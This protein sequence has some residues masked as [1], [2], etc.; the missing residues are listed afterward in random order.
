M[1]TTWRTHARDSRA[2]LG[3]VAA[4]IMPATDAGHVWLLLARTITPDGVTLDLA[5]DGRAFT[6]PAARA[7]CEQLAPAMQAAHDALLAAVAAL[8]TTDNHAR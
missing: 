4:H 1:P 8:A 6:D 3:D 5:L 2:Q 7:V